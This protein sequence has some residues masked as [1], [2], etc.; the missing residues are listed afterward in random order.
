MGTVVQ[1]F[2]GRTLWSTASAAA[3]AIFLCSAIS[4][5]RFVTSSD[6]AVGSSCR[7][8]SGH[9]GECRLITECPSALA[10][11]RRTARQGNPTTRH[12]RCGFKGTIEVVCCERNG[13]GGGRRPT[14]GGGGVRHN[15]G[16]RQPGMNQRKPYNPGSGGR[17]NQNQAQWM[18]GSNRNPSRT[19]AQTERV[20]DA[21]C[22]TYIRQCP[23]KVRPYIIEGTVAGLGEIPHMAALGYRSTDDNG[24]SMIKWN[25][26]GSLISDRYV[27]TA[28]HCTNTAIGPPVVVRLG[29]LDLAIEDEGGTPIDFSIEKTEQHPDYNL[30]YRYHDIALVRLSRSVN[31]TEFICPA[32]LY[33]GG[34]STAERRNGANLSNRIGE[35]DGGETSGNGS[36]PD[37]ALVSRLLWNG[38]EV[39]PRLNDVEDLGDKDLY[40]SGWGATS[41]PGDDES[42]SSVLLL[43]KIQPF[44]FNECN[45][46]LHEAQGRSIHLIPRG[47][48]AEGQLCAGDRNG[49]K[50]T[51]LGDSGGPLQ[52]NGKG[53][54]SLIS[55][56]GITS[57]GL[58]CG[59]SLPAVY[60]RVSH[61][62]NW[63]EQI[64][65]PQGPPS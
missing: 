51:C 7:L 27:M 32:C 59:L 63:I 53:T 42:R 20:A 1:A 49:K 25:C 38:E 30:Q 24:G 55:V 45:T 35:E 56:A 18:P 43:A 13:E 26:G 37:D 33:T 2:V 60:T 36:E 3:L 19:A 46:S 22:R 48:E 23:N 4:S 10:A 6:N 52:F 5:A 39:G 34:P 16:N 31:F 50:D 65:W 28:A 62:V 17:S 41:F 54:Q 14:P 9:S 61:Y 64:V 8:Q 11:L 29:D 44:D 21:A 12:N 15:P 47:V 40:V 58:K 57:F